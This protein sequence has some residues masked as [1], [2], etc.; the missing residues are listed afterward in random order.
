[1]VLL[2]AASA[3]ERQSAA[4]SPK[5]I[6]VLATAAQ[7]RD[8]GLARLKMAGVSTDFSAATKIW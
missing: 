8:R 5:W 7:S 1:M 3:E 4:A 6:S 2:C